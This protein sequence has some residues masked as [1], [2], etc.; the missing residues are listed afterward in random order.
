MAE[1]KTLAKDTAIYG[2]SS[3]LGK[4]LNWCLVPF[5]SYVLSSS[6]EYG[7]VTELYAWTALLLVLLTYGMETGFFRFANKSGA[8][9][10]QIYSTSMFS[11]AGSSILFILFCL[12]FLPGISSAMGYG[13]HPDYIWMMAIIVAI[14]AFCAIPFAW[15]RYKKRPMAFASLKVLM[16]F[17]NIF[18]NLF[19]LYICPKI[20]ISNPGLISWFYNPDYGVGYVFVANLISSIVGLITLIPFMIHIKWSYDG[21]LLK[22]MLKYSLPL[23]VLGIAGIMNQSFDKMMFP[24]LFQDQAYAKA[25]LGIYGACYK[26]GVVMMMFT[27]AFRY[28]YEPFVFSKQK[29]SDSKKAYSDAMKYFFIFSVFIFLGIVYF[30]D[31]LQYLVR[32]EYRSGLIVVPVVLICFIFQGI[33]FNLSF[34]Y[35]LSDKTQ[36]GAYISLIGCVMTVAGNIIF[37]PIF[38]YMGAA[39]VSCITFFV[40]MLISWMLGKKYYPISYDLKSI[41]R[42]TV[43]GVI[44]YLIGMKI[45]IESEVLRLGFR[46]FLLMLFAVY[47]L[48]KDI[49]VQSIP[50]LNKLF[51]KR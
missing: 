30:L 7:M 48:R 18:F 21:D 28:A 9:P 46:T 50:Y 11:L 15:L 29:S 5:Y 34:W 2:V 40:M 27:Q 36:W 14:D 20:Q 24:H 47:V 19:F 37:V 25:Q 17:T 43:I 49:S 13:E 42:Y 8:D 38:G 35:K 10:E 1:M 45:P 4:F 44:L 3:I 12:V 23:L 26:I 6:A 32:S 51:R 41:F 39:W 16:I 31:V 33:Y 22:K